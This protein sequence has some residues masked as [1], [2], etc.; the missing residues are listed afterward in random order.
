MQFYDIK[1]IMRCIRQ[2]NIISDTSYIKAA[3]AITFL[4]SDYVSSLVSFQG[5]RTS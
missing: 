1:Y 4:I 3:C 2:F 5:I